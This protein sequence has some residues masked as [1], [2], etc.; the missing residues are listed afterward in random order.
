MT[1]PDIHCF[2]DPYKG[3]YVGGASSLVIVIFRRFVCLGATSLSFSSVSMFLLK[4]MVFLFP[5]CCCFQLGLA[6]GS[7]SCTLSA[8]FALLN[9]ASTFSISLL[10]PDS[11]PFGDS[12][13][14]LTMLSWLVLSTLYILISFVT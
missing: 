13:F 12:C 7:A 6:L 10:P 4:K 3:L 11:W 14:S 5:F 9:E 8:L 2:L 1:L